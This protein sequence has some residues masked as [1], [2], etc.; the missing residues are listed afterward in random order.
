MNWHHVAE[1][2]AGVVAVLVVH[3]VLRQIAAALVWQWFRRRPLAESAARAAAAAGKG[4]IGGKST[5][6]QSR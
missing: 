5:G 3:K 2:A 4:G 6:S 1:S